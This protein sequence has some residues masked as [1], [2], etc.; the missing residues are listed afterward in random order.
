MLPQIKHLEVSLQNKE[1]LVD[2]MQKAHEEQLEKLAGVA[3]GRSQQWIQ[4]KAEMEK[5]YRQLLGEIHDRHSVK[6]SL[7]V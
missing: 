3:E 2:Q 7:Q 1:E 6:I 4:Q 5:H